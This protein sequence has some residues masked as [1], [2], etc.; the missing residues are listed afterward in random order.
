MKVCKTKKL[1][2]LNTNMTQ[3]KRTVQRATGLNADRPA[4]GETFNN[5]QLDDYRLWYLGLFFT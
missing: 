1:D 5:T 4:P 2:T 3:T